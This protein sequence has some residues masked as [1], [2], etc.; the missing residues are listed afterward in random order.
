MAA[1]ML[2]ARMH[3]LDEKYKLLRRRGVGDF[4]EVWLSV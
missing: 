3:T 1:M 2:A 4:G